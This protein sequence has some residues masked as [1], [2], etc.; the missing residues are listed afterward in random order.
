MDQLSLHEQQHRSLSDCAISAIDELA[1]YEVLWSRNKMTV[2]KMAELF[3]ENPMAVPSDL[4]ERLELVKMKRWIQDHLSERKIRQ[5]GIAVNQTIDYRT[6]LRDAKNPVEVITFR[7]DWSWTESPCVAV[8]GSR[9]PTKKGV[10]RCRRMVSHLVEDGY[11]IV[12]GLAKG[13]DTIAH[14]TALKMN[15]PTI[16]VIG[17]PIC[18][19]YPKENAEL[20]ER[21]ASDYCVVSGVPMRRYHEAPDYRSNRGWF[22]ERNITMSALSLAT[23]IIEASN[24]SGTLYQARAAIAQRRKLFVLNSCFEDERL[25]WPRTMEAKGAIRISEYSDMKGVLASQR[26]LLG[27]DLPEAGAD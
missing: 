8:V 16:A 23:V 27:N 1:A 10:A 11:T 25:T 6:G 7:G 9:E 20:Q 26:S 24:T 4:V 3:R 12:S 14:T 5:L 18:E 15:A 22:P 17:T 19:V 2:H 13:I 21:L